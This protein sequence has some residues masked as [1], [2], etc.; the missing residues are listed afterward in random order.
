MARNK[1]HDKTLIVFLTPSA[2]G[3]ALTYK[4][5][6]EKMSE[7]GPDLCSSTIGTN[8]IAG[9]FPLE[10]GTSR[11]HVMTCEGFQGNRDRVLRA[12][13]SRRFAL[14]VDEIDVFP[15]ES[16][17]RPALEKSL[18]DLVPISCRILLLSA[19]GSKTVMET[20]LKTYPFAQPVQTVTVEGQGFHARKDLRVEFVDLNQH[21]NNV[22]AHRRQQAVEITKL[23]NG[24]NVLIAV[25]RIY[26]G[27][28]SS[29]MLVK[30][31]R[32][33]KDALEEMGRQVHVV[34]G[35]ERVQNGDRNAILE[36]LK[37]ESN[38][39]LIATDTLVRANL[40]NLP[41]VI[42]LH[43]PK[44]P[45]EFF[46]WIG[47]ANRN[48]AAPH[49]TVYMF[50]RKGDA[51]TFVGRHMNAAKQS[52]P[53]LESMGEM[54]S[55]LTGM[56][57]ISQMLH[58]YETG[59][60]FPACGA[61][62]RCKNQYFVATESAI[63]PFKQ[64][65]KTLQGLSNLGSDVTTKRCLAELISAF[66]S[67]ALLKTLMERVGEANLRPLTQ[68]DQQYRQ[69][70]ANWE[71]WIEIC[72]EAGLI[73]QAEGLG[74]IFVTERGISW[75]TEAEK[76]P[77]EAPKIRSCH[78]K[79][80]ES[81]T[82]KVLKR[83]PPTIVQNPDIEPARAHLK[84]NAALNCIKDKLQIEILLPNTHGD[85]S[86]AYSPPPGVALLVNIRD[87]FL[88]EK[89][90]I[91]LLQ[92][93]TTKEPRVSEN[94]RNKLLAILPPSI[95]EVF[96]SD[97]EITK[98]RCKGCKRC[99]GT[100][101]D[102]SQCDFVDQ[103]ECQ[104]DC[105]EHEQKL[106]HQ[107]CGARLLLLK[108]KAEQ[109]GHDCEVLIT[110]DNH[111]HGRLP[112]NRVPGMVKILLK[113][114]A[115]DM[116]TTARDLNTLTIPSGNGPVTLP[117]D[118]IH[119][120]LANQDTVER[121]VRDIESKEGGMQ[122]AIAALERKR[123]ELEEI[124]P[125]MNLQ[126]YRG[127]TAKDGVE[128]L[129]VQLDDQRQA[130][131]Q[132]GSEIF[133][134]LTYG[135][136]KN[137]V[138]STGSKSKW[139][140]VHIARIDHQKARTVA[141]FVVNGQTEGHFNACLH[142]LD[143]QL[144]SHTGD[145]FWETKLHALVVDFDKAFINALHSFLT[146]KF[147]D[148]AGS[149]IF[150]RILRG[151]RKHWNGIIQR[152]PDLGHKTLFDA[153]GYGCV[154]LGDPESATKALKMLKRNGQIQKAELEELGLPHAA[155]LIQGDSI[156]VQWG[157]NKSWVSGWK[158]GRHNLFSR[159][160][161][162]FFSVESRVAKA[163]SNGVEMQHRAGI[164]TR[165]KSLPSQ[166]AKKTGSAVLVELYKDDCKQARRTELEA[167]NIR[168]SDHT[169]MNR[170]HRLVSRETRV[171]DGIVACQEHNAT[172]VDS[173][174]AD[175]SKKRG[176]VSQFC[177]CTTKTNC[178][179]R[180]CACVRQEKPCSGGCKCCNGSNCLNM[181]KKAKRQE[182]ERDDD[183]QVPDTRIFGVDDGAD[184]N[185]QFELSDD[186]SLSFLGNA[187]P[188]YNGSILLGDRP[189]K[190]PDNLFTT[191]TNVSG[192]PFGATNDLWQ[193][194]EG[195][196]GLEE[197]SLEE[198]L[199]EKGK[200]EA[201]GLLNPPSQL[202]IPTDTQ[203]LTEAQ[204]SQCRK[205]GDDRNEATGSYRMLQCT[206]CTQYLHLKCCDLAPPDNNQKAGRTP[207]KCG[208]C[209]GRANDN[210]GQKRKKRRF[211]SDDD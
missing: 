116:F 148:D 70:R 150:D 122:A 57:C 37:H 88:I 147:G 103:I 118:A 76:G 13:S 149:E 191:S 141:R 155:A 84:W 21:S 102:G 47:R 117:L 180:Q 74:V 172:A 12:L 115:A 65:V 36:K 177:N 71:K 17:F 67:S 142:L 68:A 199:Q 11:I 189:C 157:E 85:D 206:S 164:L 1:P 138:D 187:S 193:L 167:K 14:F 97:V 45:S 63:A 166:S 9:T 18:A 34:C 99:P 59:E 173:Q 109:G 55:I 58:L 77:M 40:K 134:D 101:E 176:M 137:Q 169:E 75:V 60:S 119:P 197:P 2:P 202:I 210:D 20:F 44:T 151:C 136:L 190:S 51:H 104:R 184:F 35:D 105:D 61:C 183:Q 114:A 66:F 90:V 181:H 124:Y 107:P 16:Q 89:T 73:G 110:I 207:Y 203:L 146:E 10:K 188:L 64:I 159:V 165:I 129:L 196:P 19:T 168:I 111:L 93:T 205:C 81:M 23:K 4:E 69:T 201:F 41:T 153:I 179:T 86:K 195:I 53:K 98:I 211:L 112:P 175:L 178:G 123:G 31:I 48:S 162:A 128:A 24:E 78:L 139:Y 96:G 5:V 145:N 95:R 194:A 126:Y 38:S 208:W 170:L 182:D 204:A 133:V 132:N 163:T 29:R 49:G 127:Y 72:L 144:A 15:L 27:E 39:V 113:K 160:A 28:G 186:Q 130:L 46:Q 174:G 6:Q 198:L 192:W 82:P 200:E 135:T 56:T 92:F 22:E 171:N 83:V 131:D 152:R 52:R 33:L 87:Q 185:A 62:P 30:S 80:V 143:D 106:I 7:I 79:A 3:A 42:L 121:I 209:K 94:N 26:E 43:P 25:Q 125:S 54:V 91:E 108:G 8:G 158:D 156:I 32:D 161:E 140:L 100:L 50:L 120:R 154:L